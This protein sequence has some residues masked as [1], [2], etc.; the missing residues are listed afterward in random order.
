MLFSLSSLP[1]IWLPQRWLLRQKILQG[2]P[3][4]GQRPSWRWARGLTL[5]SSPLLALQRWPSHQMGCKQII[6]VMIQDWRPVKN[7]VWWL[8]RQFQENGKPDR[9]CGK[10]EKIKRGEIFTCERWKLKAFKAGQRLN[11]GVPVQTQTASVNMR[12]WRT[13]GMFRK[14]A[15]SV[16]AFTWYVSCYE[17]VYINLKGGAEALISQYLEAVRSLL[18][19]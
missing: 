7:D 8:R 18:P 12:G 2:G 17:D 9:R 3:S 11:S 13:P 16:S 14:Y 4:E 19:P 5:R 15:D 1:K 10:T 6:G